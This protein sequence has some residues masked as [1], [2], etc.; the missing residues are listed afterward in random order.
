MLF[1]QDSSTSTLLMKCAEQG[2][3]SSAQILLKHQAGTEII[4]GVSKELEKLFILLNDML[5]L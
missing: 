1:V 4:N 3:T 2:L 5:S